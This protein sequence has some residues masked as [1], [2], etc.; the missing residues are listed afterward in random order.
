MSFIYTEHY[1]LELQ[2]NPNKIGQKKMPFFE[3]MEETRLPHNILLNSQF[4][5]SSD[6]VDFAIFPFAI[7]PFA[8]LTRLSTVKDDTVGF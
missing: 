3:S 8:L 5:Q 7:F 1:H 2:A 4:G 6:L